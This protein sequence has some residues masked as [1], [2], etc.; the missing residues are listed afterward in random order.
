[1]RSSDMANQ[2]SASPKNTSVHSVSSVRSS[3]SGFDA[4]LKRRFSRNRDLTVLYSGRKMSGKA[5]GWELALGE[6]T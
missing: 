3:S 2:A 5:P 4:G 1:M 6:E